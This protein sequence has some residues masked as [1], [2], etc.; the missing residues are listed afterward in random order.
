MGEEMTKE[1]MVEALKAD[2]NYVLP[3][4]ASDAE[5]ALFE[6]AKTEVNAASTG[7]AGV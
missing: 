2:A 3:E 1:A 7:D 4:T 5:K 6:E